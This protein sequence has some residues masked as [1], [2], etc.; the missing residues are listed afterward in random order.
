MQETTR[1]DIGKV[2]ADTVQ[3]SV[4]RVVAEDLAGRVVADQAAVPVFHRRD[5]LM[6]VAVGV[7]QADSWYEGYQLPPLFE[8][9]L[10][11]ARVLIDGVAP[12]G[13][14]VIQIT[15]GCFGNYL[16]S[17]IGGGQLPEFVEWNR[18][19]GA[20]EATIAFVSRFNPTSKK[21]QFIDLDA[22]VQNVELYLRS[23]QE[24]WE[25][26][27]QIRL[28]C[29]EHR[30]DQEQ[31]ARLE[32]FCS[33]VARNLFM[34]VWVEGN[35]MVDIIQ[36]C[37][38]LREYVKRL[39]ERAMQFEKERGVAQERIRE[40]EA[41]AGLCSWSESGEERKLRERDYSPRQTAERLEKTLSAAQGMLLRKMAELEQMKREKE[42]LVE[43][44]WRVGERMKVAAQNLDAGIEEVESEMSGTDAVAGFGG[45]DEDE[46]QG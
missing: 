39:K 18:W 20:G 12:R 8:V 16:K 15:P 22:L 23:G 38:D 30:Q 35:P 27:K 13:G 28:M 3:A 24:L 6:A 33:E 42:A 17:W 21:R 5:L 31:I 11:R 37:D 32:A 4:A 29:E 2:V 36:G 43:K 7:I 41:R 40:L 45:S 14:E 25:K 9:A 26:R 34:R 46:G 44:L 10:N 19:G 1:Q